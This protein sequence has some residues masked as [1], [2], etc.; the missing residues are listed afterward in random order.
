MIFQA[1]QK[2]R[3]SESYDATS[4]VWRGV[5][6]AHLSR[7]LNV[8]EELTVERTKLVSRREKNRIFIRQQDPGNPG[9]K[10]AAPGEDDVLGTWA[11]LNTY[12]TLASH[13]RGTRP[14]PID[15][16]AKFAEC[17]SVLLAILRPSTLTTRDELD[18]LL[19]E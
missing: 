11:D 7:A 4:K 18:A 16:D 13:H 19:Q 5:I 9:G 3:A 2:A 12:F 17:T 15:F 6:D 14:T 8:V 10:V 1:F